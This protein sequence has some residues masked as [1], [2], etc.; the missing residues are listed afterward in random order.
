MTLRFDYAMLYAGR[1]AFAA[2][3]IVQEAGAAQRV[4]REFCFYA[5]RAYADICY[6]A[7]HAMP[8]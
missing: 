1:K 4:S 6:Y 2:F 8:P 7:Y 3:I 5:Q